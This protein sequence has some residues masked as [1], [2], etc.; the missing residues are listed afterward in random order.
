MPALERDDVIA[1]GMTGAYGSSMFSTYNGRPRPT[2]IAW[3]G[4]R[5]VA[6][7]KRGSLRSL[8]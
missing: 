6:W 2:E 3:D 8:P 1:I 5:L 4:E 7:R